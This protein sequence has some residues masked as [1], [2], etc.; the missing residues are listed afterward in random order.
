MAITTS[1]CAGDGSLVPE[2]Y[3]RKTVCANV[4]KLLSVFQSEANTHRVA[5]GAGR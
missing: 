2:N 4:Y 3:Y 5:I 1:P